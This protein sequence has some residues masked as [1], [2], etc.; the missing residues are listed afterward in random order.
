MFFFNIML[1]VL[2]P[3]SDNLA[4]WARSIVVPETLRGAL[5]ARAE[6]F[7]SS[8]NEGFYFFSDDRQR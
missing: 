4:K 8:D 2:S 1:F 3:P 7:L 5:G 6:M